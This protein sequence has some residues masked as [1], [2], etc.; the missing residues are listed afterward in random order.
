MNK[1]FDEKHLVPSKILLIFSLIIYFLLLIKTAW[2]CD[3]AYIT[4][5]TVDNFINGYGLRWNVAER[6]QTYTHPLWMFLIA[7]F[8]FFTKE[9]FFTSIFLSIIIS[10]TTVFLIIF[11][12]A[13]QFYNALIVILL[14]LFS[15]VFIDFSTSGL[16]NPLSHLLFVILSIVYINEGKSLKRKLLIGFLSSLI[17]LNRYDFLFIL[18]PFLFIELIKISRKEFLM[19]ALGFSPL[20]IWLSFSLWYYGFLFPNTAYAKLNTGIP[21]LSLIKEGFY[22][23]K[24]S[25][26]IDPVTLTAIASSILLVLIYKNYKLLPFVLGII[27]YFVYLIFVGG[28][29]MAGRFFTVPFILSLVILSKI[30][31]KNITSLKIFLLIILLT[32]F[33]SIYR[34]IYN[35]SFDSWNSIVKFDSDS[36]MD[37]RKFYYSGSN[38]L[39]ALKGDPM[40]SHYWV[41]V[42]REIKKN[43]VK[44]ITTINMGFQGYY[45]GSETYLIDKLA[46]SD[47]LLSRL[48][49]ESNW[50]I[51]HYPRLIPYGYLESLYTNSNMIKD[52][53]LSKYY[54]KIRII[55]RG[56]L[57]DFSRLV[58]ILK[59]NLGHY[60]YLVQ[61][62]LNKM[63]GHEEN[64]VNK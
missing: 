11:N 14:V 53:S 61:N 20:F 31:I 63:N 43:K 4:F 17:L 3:D 10:L 54:E 27:F 49:S 29:F 1:I 41:Q 52:S 32:G 24:E 34:T 12:L 62:Y 59:F 57:F 7:F 36:V 40:P 45:A 37:E 2:L 6:V 33:I 56:N 28:D 13:K 23:F 48:P 42:G 44:I 60:D 9:V 35:K 50:R 21:R 22:Y 18:I 8:Y 51:G 46:L 64:N 30:D 26:A 15:K 39:N 19:F 47:P 16:E 38:L 5:R 58:D 55:T 25:F